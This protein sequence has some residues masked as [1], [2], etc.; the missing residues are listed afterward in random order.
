MSE[1]GPFQ[2]IPGTLHLYLYADFWRDVNFYQ[3]GHIKTRDTSRFL[4]SMT[5]GGGQ[6]PPSLYF[7][8]GLAL[9]FK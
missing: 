9:S 2:Q 8:R 4:V 7:K 1:N 5:T 3:N 6:L